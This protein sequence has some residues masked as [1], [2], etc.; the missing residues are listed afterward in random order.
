MDVLPQIPNV[1]DLAQMG[2]GGVK[3][4][5]HAAWNNPY[6]GS[7]GRSAFGAAVGRGAYALGAGTVGRG[8]KYLSSGPTYQS[9]YKKNGNG[10]GAARPSVSVRTPYSRGNARVGGYENIE[11]KFVN[12]TISADA[13]TTVWAGGEMD[14][15]TTDALSG[16]AQGDGES[17]RD[18]RTYQIHS[19]YLKG[20]LTST[21]LEA[22]GAP[23]DDALARIVLVWDT[24]TN[25]QQLS[26]EDVFDSIGA[27]L[28]INSQKNLSNTVR[29]KVLKDKVIRLPIGEAGVNDGGINSFSVGEIK[30]PFK[31]SHTFKVPLKVRTTGTTANVAS[32]ADNS[33]H[34]I[35]N[36]TSTTIKITYS[37]RIR[38]TN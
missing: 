12:Y 18:G 38:F 17:Q 36:A 2:Y 30:V 14:D 5:L 24:Q 32:I 35:G 11:K 28:D 25:G 23:V 1:Y 3:P 10:G 27:G 4:Y 15:G 34:L 16:V 22:Q 21:N 7:A 6:L 33:L 9:P 8:L 20:F 26:A 29:F 19:V 31:M 37:S 13:F